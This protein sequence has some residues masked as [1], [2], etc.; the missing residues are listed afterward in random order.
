MTESAAGDRLERIRMALAP[1]DATTLELVDDSAAHHGHAGARDGGGHYRLRVVS[2]RFHGLAK[3][4]RHRL[5]YDLLFAL[6]Q[7]DIHAL[8]LVLLTPEELLAARQPSAAPVPGAAPPS[9]PRS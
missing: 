4:A 5:V 6:M 7:R 1:L 9:S 8:S 3:V 2:T